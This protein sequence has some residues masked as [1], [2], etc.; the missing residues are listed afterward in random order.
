MEASVAI[1]ILPETIDNDETIRVVDKVIEYIE[2]T[3]LTYYVGPCETAIEGDFDQLF[4]ILKEC[5]K[6]AIKAGTPGV[7]SY[8]KVTYHPEGEILSIDK[9]VT[10]HHQ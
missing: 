4:E 9:K 10:K 8:I 2:S 7:A 6:I 5:H 3:G 1:Q